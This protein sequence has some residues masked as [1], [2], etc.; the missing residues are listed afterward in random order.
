M[1]SLSRCLWIKFVSVAAP[2]AKFLVYS[3]K[4]VQCFIFVSFLIFKSPTIFRV[5]NRKF[6]SKTP[7][8][9]LSWGNIWQTRNFRHLWLSWLCNYLVLA[10]CFPIHYFPQ[11]C[12][13]IRT[14]SS[15]NAE[16][17]IGLV[18]HIQFNTFV[19]HILGFIDSVLKIDA[20]FV[21]W[22]VFW[23]SW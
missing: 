8:D 14:Y 23:S 22:L 11:V 2:E 4:R 21:F 17:L 19:L 20:V 13:D 7:F 15:T 3:H 1:I 10:Q 16:L 9:I 12:D 5:Q 18:V 6:P